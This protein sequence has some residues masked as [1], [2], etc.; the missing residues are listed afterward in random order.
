MAD[1][2]IYGNWTFLKIEV[3]LIMEPPSLL[4]LAYKYL[5]ILGKTLDSIYIF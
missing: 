5:Q 1:R 3:I 4:P 2:A